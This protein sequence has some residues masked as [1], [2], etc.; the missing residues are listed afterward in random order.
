[1][2]HRELLRPLPPI[3]QMHRER[4]SPT[5]AQACFAAVV[6]PTAPCPFY[7]VGLQGQIP[8]GWDLQTRVPPGGTSEARRDPSR[9]PISCRPGSGRWLLPSRSIQAP[10]GTWLVLC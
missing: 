10:S 7:K 6:V 9:P 3:K 5:R 2:R 8:R 1:M 4:E